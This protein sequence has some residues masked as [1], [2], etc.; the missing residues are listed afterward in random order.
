MPS[1]EASPV[2]SLKDFFEASYEAFLDASS[3]FLEA[4]SRCL[5]SGF[6]S[7]FFIILLTSFLLR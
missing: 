4:F 7:A 2:P 6:F 5:P 3:A 1:P